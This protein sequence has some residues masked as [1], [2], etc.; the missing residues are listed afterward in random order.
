MNES[1][2]KKKKEKGRV[3]AKAVAAGLNYKEWV[4]AKWRNMEIVFPSG[5]TAWSDVKY[6][7]T[8]V[9]FGVHENIVGDNEK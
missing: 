8:W 5:E 9:H 4:T 1:F 3:G 7:E 2:F 6:G